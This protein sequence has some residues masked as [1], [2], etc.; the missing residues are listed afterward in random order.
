MKKTRH[1][2]FIL[3]LVLPIYV[4]AATIL[5]SNNKK[6]TIGSNF[7]VSVNLDYGKTNIKTAHYVISYDPTCFSLSELKWSQAKAT[8][9][10][11]EGKLYIDK[12]ETS[13]SWVKGSPFSMSFRANQECSKTI[14]I[15]ETAKATDDN[16]QEIHQ[17][18]ADINIETVQSD[19]NNQLASLKVTNQKLNSIFD[20]SV[21]NYSLSV[22]KDI[23]EIEV[24]V[25]KNNNKQTITS[26]GIIPNEEVNS[27]T[28]HISYKLEYG[29]NKIYVYV[30]AESGE[31]N[32][33]TILATRQEE[34][35]KEALLKRLTVSDTNIKLIDGIFEYESK[36]PKSVDNILITAFPEDDKAEI[37]GT[38]N[39]KIIDGENLF[40]IKVKSSSGDTKTYKIKIIRTDEADIVQNTNIKSIKINGE[41][42]KFT[43]RQYLMGVSEK[44]NN[45]KIDLTLESEDAYYTIEG[46]TSFSKDINTVV[47]T[48]NCGTESTNYYIR[49]YKKDSNKVYLKSIS[50]LNKI[51]INTVIE[52]DEKDNHDISKN[53][54]NLLSSTNKLLY[55]NVLNDNMGLLYSL[56][57]D[58]DVEIENIN[59]NMKKESDKPLTYQTSIRSGI[60][61]SLF[62][63]TEE[64]SDGEYIRI[65]SYDEN[66]NYHLVSKSADIIDG[67]V[68][69]TTT[70]DKYYVFTKDT[71]IKEDDPI[72]KLF[73]QYKDYIIY[74]SFIL[75]VIIILLIMAKINRKKKHKLKEFNN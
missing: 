7:L 26:N 39:K 55:Y 22:A 48:V 58:K 59:A 62:L 16:N 60:N 12:E 54:I 30:K 29:L 63:D 38:G 23:D 25:K 27:N 45:I 24:V 15:K 37:T 50:D 32:T 53:K 74:G 51:V 21:N 68:E 14:D 42:V 3:L 57:L 28:A 64:F 2:L 47:I 49:V 31:V 35:K 20:K 66:R 52:T 6:P 10:S 5:I 44:N 43:N 71:L 33:Y 67:Y 13:P 70:G 61:V 18:F 69:F 75:V 9:R 4:K 65:Y 73:K 36:V 72:T 41:K 11:E 34:E 46:N 19:T 1:I 56:I 17:S 40:E 8:Y